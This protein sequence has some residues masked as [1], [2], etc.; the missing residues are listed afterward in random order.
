[1]PELSNYKHNI[2][3]SFTLNSLSTVYS[4]ITSAIASVINLHSAS[5]ENLA[6]VGCI[7]A[8]HEIKF[9]SKKIAKIQHVRRHLILLRLTYKTTNQHK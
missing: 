1:M 4:Q 7:L 8:L 2:P 5:I 3:S 6:I 9:N